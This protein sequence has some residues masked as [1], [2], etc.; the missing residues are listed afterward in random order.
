MRGEEA[1]DG[2]RRRCVTHSAL[3]SNEQQQDE[4]LGKAC[5]R[6]LLGGQGS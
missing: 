2:P 6:T 5:P 4:G 3:P 1:E